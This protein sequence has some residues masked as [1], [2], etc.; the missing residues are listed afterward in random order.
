M[1]DSKVLHS[2]RAGI[3]IMANFAQRFTGRRVDELALA[4]NAAFLHK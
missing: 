2:R 4:F 1:L 3:Q